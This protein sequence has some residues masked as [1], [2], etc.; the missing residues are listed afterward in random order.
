MVSRL[1][2]ILLS[3]ASAT[4]LSFSACGEEPPASAGCRRDSDCHEG[5]VCDYESSQCVYPTDAGDDASGSGCEIDPSFDGCGRFEGKYEI[6]GQNCLFLLP[7]GQ[8]EEE[9]RYLG[10]VPEQNCGVTVTALG[11]AGSDLVWCYFPTYSD[12]PYTRTPEGN[13][14]L[15]PQNGEYQIIRCSE[16]ELRVEWSDDQCFALLTKIHLREG[17][18][19]C[20][21]TEE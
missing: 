13:V 7:N 21:D 16:D 3:L 18:F 15:F 14:L 6:T 19:L 10:F 20:A 12:P 2:K 17:E 4:A 11:A 9:V 8:R 1:E 5:R